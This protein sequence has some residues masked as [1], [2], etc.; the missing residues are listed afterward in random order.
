[1][2]IINVLDTSVANLIA[3]G[4]VVERPCSAIKELCENSMD[5]GAKNIT[6]EIQNGGI[7]LMRVTD[8]GCGMS[9]EDAVLCIKSHATSKIKEAK[10]LNKIITF[11]FRGEALA[12]ITAVTDARIMTKRKEDQTGTLLKCE[13]GTVTEF[14]EGGYPNGTT[15]ICERLFARTRPR[16]KFLKSDSSEGAAC[17]QVVERLALSHPEVSFKY[18]ADGVMKFS[19]PGDGVLLNTVYSV[20]GREF[21]KNLLEVNSKS[22]GIAVQG[23]IGTP[24][25]CRGNRAMQ[26]FFVNGRNVKSA[27]MTAALE[28]A[29]RTHIMINKFP[30]CVIN[31]EVSP[32][33]VDVNIHPSKM[34]VKFSEEKAI[35]DAIYYTIKGVLERN[36][37]RQSLELPEEK[38]NDQEKQAIDTLTKE[39]KETPKEKAK[40]SDVTIPVESKPKFEIEKREDN[41]PNKKENN[42]SS[43]FDYHAHYG[44]INIEKD[45]EPDL[46]KIPQSSDAGLDEYKPMPVPEYTIVGEVFKTYVIIQTKDEMIMIDKH[47]A[48]ERINYEKLRMQYK[49]NKPDTQLILVPHKMLLSDEE[50]VAAKENKQLIEKLGYTFDLDGKTLALTGVPSG[51]DIKES[52][53][54]LITLLDAAKN[55]QSIEVANTAHFEKVLY[56]VACKASIKGGRVYDEQTL[57]WIIDNVFRYDCIKNCPHGRTI[58]F[59]L[60]ERELN[61]RF[62]REE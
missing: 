30:V 27:Q 23:Y 49:K 51:T 32:M 9:S 53:D 28:A 44:V 21:S 8:D 56:T 3:A 19:S 5:A 17:Q 25:N 33:Y 13:Y 11:G 46:P 22:G 20:F 39:Y 34:E 26:I 62:G 37:K 36:V 12:A 31:V 40:F 55:G 61:I 38:I 35:F 54:I 29:F 14:S 7:S 57:R 10:D 45:D 60:S 2:S 16:L 4:E 50:S 6:V 15:I 59:V 47:A 1:M 43:E 18:I 48:H 52:E 41:R 58:G 42:T 24:E